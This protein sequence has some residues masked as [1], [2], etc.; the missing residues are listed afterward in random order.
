MSALL[1][2]IYS[3]DTHFVFGP[4]RTKQEACLWAHRTILTK[5]PA[6]DFLIKQASFA[7]PKAGLEPIKVVMTKV[8]LAA[9]AV[10]LKYIS[11]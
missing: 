4:I 1:R 7:N 6:F 3:I 10:L 11:L 5:Y 9:F 8:S 2:D